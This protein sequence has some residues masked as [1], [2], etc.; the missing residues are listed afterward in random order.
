M[1]VR[2]AVTV[3][4]GVAVGVSPVVTVCV[5]VPVGVEGAEGEGDREK[6]VPAAHCHPL[7]ENGAGS[8]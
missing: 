5:G 3:C 8:A 4:V 1:G 7:A 6:T 2:P